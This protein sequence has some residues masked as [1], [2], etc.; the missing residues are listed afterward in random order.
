[1]SQAGPWLKV[2]KALGWLF[3][4]TLGKIGVLIASALIAAGLVDSMTSMEELESAMG[5]LTVV[6]WAVFAVEV[7]VIAA[8]VGYARVPEHSG[9]K[10]G[11]IAAVVLAVVCLGFDFLSTLPMFARDYD[12]LA[13]TSPWETFSSFG[14]I[15]F[16]FAQMASFKALANHLGAPEVARA[17]GTCMLLVGILIG[18]AIVGGLLV[19][20]SKSE[21]LGILLVVALIGLAIWAFVLHLMVIFQLSQRTRAEEDV[22]SAF[23]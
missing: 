22:A 15:A 11:A 17:A 13:E 7:A 16:L 5:T 9:A 4:L 6:M 14:K 21:V 3:W 18:V 8:L 20:A 19:G 2:S 1:M 12:A 23:T 10:G